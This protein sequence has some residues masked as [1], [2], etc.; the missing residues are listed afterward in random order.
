MNTITKRHTTDCSKCEGKADRDMDAELTPHKG[1][2]WVTENERWS[3]SMGVPPSQVA[4][5]RKRFPDSVYH[6]D[7]RLLN[8]GRQHKLKQAKERDMIE[9]NDSTCKAWFR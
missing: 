3:R 2:K 7:G 1:C 6:D 5:F 4:E 9:L 8:K